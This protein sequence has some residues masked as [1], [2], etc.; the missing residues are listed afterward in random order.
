MKLDNGRR[1]TSADGQHKFHPGGYLL[2]DAILQDDN[3]SQ[4]QSFDLFNAW[5]HIVGTSNKNFHYKAQYSLGIAHD[6][7]NQLGVILGYT[8]LLSEQS[9]SESQLSWVKAVRGAA[10]RCALKRRILF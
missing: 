2:F 5:L 3:A 10:D 9:L 6:F 4:S 7:N 8:E 1:L